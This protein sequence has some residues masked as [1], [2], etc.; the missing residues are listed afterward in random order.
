MIADPDFAKV[1]RV[2]QAMM[3]MTK[4]DTAGLEKAYTGQ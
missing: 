1:T 2:M 4:F 3:G